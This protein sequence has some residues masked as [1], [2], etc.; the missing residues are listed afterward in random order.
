LRE[1]AV[2]GPIEPNAVDATS[3]SAFRAPIWTLISAAWLVPAILAMV[4]EY[5]QGRLGHEAAPGF[6][7]VAWRGGDWLIY[8]ALTPVVFVIAHR[9]PLR[10]GV[11]ARHIALH[12]FISLVFC[13]AWAGA[14]VLL[15][16]LLVP[17]PGGAATL[18][19]LVSW[20]F[21]TLPFGVAVYFSVLGIEHATYYFRAVRER[22]TQAAV[23]TAQLAEARLGALRMQLHPHFLF[24][25]LNAIGVLV[26]DHETAA[27]ARMVELLSDVLRQV[28]T[29]AQVHET[30]LAEELTF[31]RNYLAIEQVRFADR[32]RVTVDVEPVLL[33]ALVPAFILQPIIENAM[34][35]G[36][37]KR[38]D[39]GL[40]VIA[41]RREKDDVVMMVSDDGPGLGPHENQETSGVGVANTRA[42]LATLFG[43]RASL[44]LETAAGGGTRATLR[45]PYRVAPPSAGRSR[46]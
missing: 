16:A 22:E 17:G 14:G 1:L 35:H 2:S 19:F 20:F 32:L 10:R 27:A 30:T 26:R 11:L 37:A 39:A 13:A 25:S 9:F 7:E 40:V 33:S 21:V 42:R 46:G 43:E 6:G 28:L 3:S 41:V 34:R 36:I 38:S 15:R 44:T 12:F 5:M 29:A 8:G 23:L 24:N 4:D 31:V 18:P 45:F